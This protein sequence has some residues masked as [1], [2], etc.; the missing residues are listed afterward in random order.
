MLQKLGLSMQLL[1]PAQARL[2]LLLNGCSVDLLALV[3]LPERLQ[4]AHQSS[5]LLFALSFALVP[6]GHA[7][8]DPDSIRRAI[9][10]LLLEGVVVLKLCRVQPVSLL[11]PTRRPKPGSA[12]RLVVHPES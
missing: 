2:N 1:A 7:G 3:T 9:V 12:P 8:P 4:L 11:V 6:F 10:T 5:P